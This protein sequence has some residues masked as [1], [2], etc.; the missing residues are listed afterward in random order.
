LLNR[1]I[2]KTNK[3]TNKQKRNRNDMKKAEIERDSM[4]RNNDSLI[5]VCNK[6]EI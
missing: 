3:Q 2:E 1:E 5:E 4:H 6:N